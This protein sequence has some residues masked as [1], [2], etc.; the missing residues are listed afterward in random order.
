MN[1]PTTFAHILFIGLFAI[2]LLAGCANSGTQ[3]EANRIQ[4]AKSALDELAEAF[5]DGDTAEVE[6]RLGTMR[7][8]Y[9]ATLGALTPESRAQVG[10]TLRQAE[11]KGV[12]EDYFIFDV[13]MKLPERPVFTSH[14]RVY[15]SEDS[16]GKIEIVG[17]AP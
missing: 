9:S 2:G 15:F 5:E 11:Y 6:E 12:Y 17:I 7:H 10:R 8:Q 14:I 3:S 4:Q 13:D 1:K 16:A